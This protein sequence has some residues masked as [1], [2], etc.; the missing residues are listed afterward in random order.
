M[1]CD[2]AL[3]IFTTFLLF[4]A[5]LVTAANLVTAFFFANVLIAIVFVAIVLVT[6]VTTVLIATT[7][8]M[9]LPRS[10]VD[11]LALIAAGVISIGGVLGGCANIVLGQ[12]TAG[13]GMDRETKAVSVTV[14]SLS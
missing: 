5:I 8:W 12:K 7:N 9:D 6:A 2:D 13:L 10:T 14:A 4:V 3:F 1:E 11:I